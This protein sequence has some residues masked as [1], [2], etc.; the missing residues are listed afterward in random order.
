M[1]FSEED[2]DEL[3]RL[4]DT[5]DNNT[6]SAKLPLPDKMHKEVLLS[7]LASARDTLKGVLVRNGF[8]PWSD[9]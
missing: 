3:G 5:L 4:V 8:N 2:L 9:E 7:C 1:T 6:Y